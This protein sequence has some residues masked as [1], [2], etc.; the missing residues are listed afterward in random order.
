VT[1]P[2]PNRPRSEGIAPSPEP[3]SWLAPEAADVYRRTLAAHPDID[4]DALAVYASAV[5]DFQ[6]AQDLLNKSTPLIQGAKGALVRNPLQ[7]V[8]QANAAQVRA[9]AKDL[10]LLEATDVPAVPRR[11]RNQRAAEATIAALRQSGRIEVVDEAT[12]ALVRTLASALDRLEPEEDAAPLASLARTQ[13][14]ALKM[15]R[16]QS[17]DSADALATLLASLSTEMGDAPES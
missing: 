17:D 8:K 13:I 1:R 9:L 5:A 3:P 10:G 14:Q 15:L 6:R 12:I 16:G 4:A 11:Y 2:G 7:S